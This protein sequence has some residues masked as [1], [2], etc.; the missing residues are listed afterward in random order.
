[1]SPRALDIADLGFQV[2]DHVCA[3]Y[4]EGGNAL[5]DIFVDYVSKGLQAGTNAS[6]SASPTR[7]PR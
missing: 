6:L 1:M 2:G 3:C 5:D 4:N 7:R